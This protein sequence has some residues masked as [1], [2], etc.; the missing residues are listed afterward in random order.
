MIDYAINK[1]SETV[2]NEEAARL[3]VADDSFKNI[4]I[5]GNEH[6]NLM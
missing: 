1:F 4:T 5:G 6:G 3:K 2:E